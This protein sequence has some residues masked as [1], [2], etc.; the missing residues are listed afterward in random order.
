M[1]LSASLTCP[2]ACIAVRTCPTGSTVP[3]LP[4][5]CTSFCN[6]SC[7]VPLPSVIS[8]TV[9]TKVRKRSNSSFALLSSSCACPTASCTA[10]AAVSISSVAVAMPLVSVY[11]TSIK[12]LRARSI[13]RLT[14]SRF[15]PIS[16]KKLSVSSISPSSTRLMVCASVCTLV[17]MVSASAVA[18]LPAACAVS[19]MALSAS[20][21]ACTSATASP[22]APE[23]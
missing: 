11:G 2:M 13:W 21:I 22:A 14:S 3:K 6:F 20:F 5:A 7:A 9:C 1:R 4:N 8:P 10:C 17:N 16:A 18:A 23:T 12:F 15:F 19:R